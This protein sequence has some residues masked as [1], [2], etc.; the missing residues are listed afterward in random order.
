MKNQDAQGCAVALTRFLAVLALAAA[1][2]ALIAWGLLF[3]VHAVFG[4]PIDFW[5]AFVIIV[6][7]MAIFW[8]RG[9]GKS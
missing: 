9:Y 8:A 7:V 3:V 4:K 5:P 2:A 1:I 6:L